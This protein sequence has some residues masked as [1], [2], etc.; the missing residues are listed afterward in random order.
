MPPGLRIFLVTGDYS[1]VEALAHYVLAGAV[2]RG[3]LDEF[4]KLWAVHGRDIKR[5]HPGLT[6][7]EAILRGAEYSEAQRIARGDE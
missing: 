3:D 2:I 6:F 7:A 4:R 5:E 1:Q